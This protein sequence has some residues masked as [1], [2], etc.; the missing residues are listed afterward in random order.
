MLRVFLDQTNNTLDPYKK[1]DKEIKA[2]FN[3]MKHVSRTTP[4]GEPIYV[5][6]TKGAHT[7]MAE[8]AGYV[9]LADKPVETVEP[10]KAAPKAQKTAP[11]KT[12]KSTKK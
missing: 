2:G 8:S 3:V 1:F 4:S 5:V 9:K 12:T 10:K 11:K 7:E 6:R